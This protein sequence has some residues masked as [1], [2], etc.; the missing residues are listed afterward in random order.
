MTP[1][2]LPRVILR[3]GKQY[4]LDVRLSQLRN[5]MNPHDFIDCNGDEVSTLQILIAV[6][7]RNAAGA[8]D[9]SD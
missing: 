9:L 3:N 5:V 4:F 6:T 2:M 1:T 7:G 8:H